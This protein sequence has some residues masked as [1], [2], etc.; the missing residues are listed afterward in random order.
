MY[1]LMVFCVATVTA[2]TTDLRTGLVSAIIM[3]VGSY[4]LRLNHLASCQIVDILDDAEAAEPKVNQHIRSVAIGVVMLLSW[5]FLHDISKLFD[6]GIVGRGVIIISIIMPV[7]TT[8]FN[9][10]V[11]IATNVLHIGVVY[12]ASKR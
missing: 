3:V 1:W 6:Y 2:L 5:Y 9:I 12:T 11:W 7:A 8:I 10:V 4:S